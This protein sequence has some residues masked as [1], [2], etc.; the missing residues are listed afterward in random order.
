MMTYLT[1]EQTAKIKRAAELA[2]EVQ[3]E[4]GMTVHVIASRLTGASVLSISHEGSPPA[5]ALWR[6]WASE[7]SVVEDGIDHRWRSTPE[8]PAQPTRGQTFEDWIKVSR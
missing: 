5:N 3:R 8:I 4:I 2:E 6:S 7:W 1:D